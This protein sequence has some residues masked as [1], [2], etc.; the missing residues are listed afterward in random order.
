MLPRLKQLRQE[1]GISQQHLA[2]A[3][4]VSQPS[5]NKYENHSTEPDIGSLICLADYFGTSVDYIIGHTDERRRIERTEPWQLNAAEAELIARYRS[6]NA[7]ER[8]CV[9]H[10]IRMLLKK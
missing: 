10:V 8:A 9:E 1:Q 7:E 5:I 3:V 2:D 4:G 6:L